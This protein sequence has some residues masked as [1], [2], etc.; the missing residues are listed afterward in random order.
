MDS[1]ILIPGAIRKSLLWSLVTG[2]LTIVLGAFLIA[3]PF[4]TAAIT[5]LLL[6]WILILVGIAQ[7]VFALHSELVGGFFAK[8]FLGVLYSITGLALVLFP[9]GGVAAL[10]AMLG[11]LLIVH[12]GLT[13]ITAFQARP[14][15][16]AGWFLFDAI[17]SLCLGLLIILHWPSSSVWTIGNI[18][19][20][21]VLMSGLSRI[22]VT[23]NTR[24]EPQP[25]RRST[26]NP[27]AKLHGCVTAAGRLLSH[28]RARTRRQH[29]ETKEYSVRSVGKAGKLA[30][31]NLQ[32]FWEIVEL[33]DLAEGLEVN[34][35]KTPTWM[36]VSGTPEFK[37][38]REA[39]A[40]LE[41]LQ[42][43]AK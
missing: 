38:K 12:A 39:Q 42:K 6:G 1:R 34:L 32:R 4:T 28:L 17:V 35:P 14:R 36:R 23:M 3:Y 20:L 18:V 15:N 29:M 31:G 11:T 37:T 25:W 43:P 33:Q 24:S 7:F 10:T 27:R 2:I 9:F 22:M 21:A 13:T 16:C 8:A 30:N 5:T 26:I 40:A 41:Q 19:G